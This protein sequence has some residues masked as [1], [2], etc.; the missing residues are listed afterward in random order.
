MVQFPVSA[1][2]L[3]VIG[4]VLLSALLASVRGFTREVLA[5]ASWVIAIFAAYSLH[6][7][8]LQYFTPYISNPQ[9]ALAVTIAVL[10]LGI[11]VIVSLITVKISDLIL[12]S[13]IGALD[14]SLGFLFGALRGFLIATIAFMFFDKLV[15]EKQHPEWVRDAK[16]RPILQEAGTQLLTFLPTDPAF[17]DR[18]KPSALPA[19]GA[20]TTPE[21]ADPNAAPAQ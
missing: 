4:I 8:L 19:N 13:R 17:L 3:I 20:T 10:F 14:R 21:K 16:L 11:L 5:I 18:L 12:D 1:L 15:G 6:P 2:D 9:I 7:S